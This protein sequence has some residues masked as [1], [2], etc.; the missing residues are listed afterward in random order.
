MARKK[1]SAKT[2]K[3]PD[4]VFEGEIDLHD[5]SIATMVE[6]VGEEVVKSNACADMTIAAQ[7][8]IRACIEKGKSDAEIKASST[9]GTWHEDL[10]RP[11]RSG[12]VCAE[13]VQYYDP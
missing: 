9:P 6:W 7:S 10:P 11:S 8:L 2:S 3:V 5:D 4:R 13:E 1:I 12:R